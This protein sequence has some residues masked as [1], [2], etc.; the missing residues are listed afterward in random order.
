MKLLAKNGD[1]M[2]NLTKLEFP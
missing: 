2:I 1:K